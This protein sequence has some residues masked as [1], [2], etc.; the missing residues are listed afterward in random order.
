M[1]TCDLQRLPSSITRLRFRDEGAAGS[2]SLPPQLQQLTGL[3][4]LHLV[5]CGFLPALL[6]S[7]TQLRALHLRWCLLLPNK[8]EG[9]AAFLDVLPKLSC[10]EDLHLHS[11]NLDTHS[12]MPQRFFVLTASSHLTQLAVNS[13][14]LAP[15]PKGA[16]QH[17]FGAG[18][19]MPQLR[20]C[21]LLVL[22]SWAD[23]GRCCID[24]A[25]LE[26]IDRCC[27]ALRCL[28]INGTVQPGADL[29]GLLQLPDSCTALSVGGAAFTDAAVPTLVQ[30]TQLKELTWGYFPQLTGTGLAQLTALDLD[31]L[32]VD[33]WASEMPLT[34]H[35]VKVR[36]AKDALQ[37]CHRHVVL[38]A[39]VG[40]SASHRQHSQSPAFV[41]LLR[42]NSPSAW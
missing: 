19:Q 35:V 25:D 16:V 28:G 10:L 39:A 24:S 34:R 9:T 40:S 8:S 32:H 11:V 38:L 27:P 12:I 41:L 6:G 31:R 36:H 30:L 23:V 1:P 37:V 33:S 4:H 13:L 18:R 14:Q 17:M 21:D 7:I 15:I 42:L 20:A 3:L 5:R 22:G 29:S 26:L 2:L